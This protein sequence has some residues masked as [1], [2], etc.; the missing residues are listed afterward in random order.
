MMYP[1][2]RELAADGIPVTVTCRVLGFSPQAYHK[3][4]ANPVS[5]RDWSDAHLGFNRS[6]Q[7]LPQ[8]ERSAQGRVERDGSKTAACTGEGAQLAED[9]GPASGDDPAREAGHP[10]ARDRQ[11]V[12]RIAAAG[13]RGPVAEGGR[14]PGRGLAPLGCTAVPGGPDRGRPGVPARRLASR[15]RAPDRSK[16]LH[17]F[18]R[19]GR[20]RGSCLVPANEGP[21]AGSRPG[22]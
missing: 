17:G 11:D 12:G 5:T 14:L 15:D 7:H 20:E 16:S 2:V 9:E 21:P 13:Q 10:P 22:T 1:L 4:K 6:M 8:D 3:W 19:G 18:P